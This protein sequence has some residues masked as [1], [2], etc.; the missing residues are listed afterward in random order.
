MTGRKLLLSTAAAAMAWT[1]IV[2]AT[3]GLDVRI[4]G[5]PLRARDTFRAA[6]LSGALLLVYA[7]AYR[8]AFGADVE[9]LADIWRRRSPVIAAGAALVA[10]AVSL[11]F[12]SFAVAGADTYGYVSQAYDWAR[13]QLPAAI[14]LPVQFPWPSADLLTTP[15]GYRPGPQPHTM[16]PTY[17]PGLPLLMAVMLSVGPIGPFLITPACAAITVWLT[18]LLG[19]RVAGPAVGA[20]AAILIAASPVEQFQSLWAMSDVPSAACWTAAVLASLGTSR[21]S[22]AIGGLGTALALFVRPNLPLLALVPLAVVLTENITRRE[23]F[24]RAALFCAP[25]LPVVV[26]VGALNALWYG[27]PLRSGYGAAGELYAFENVRTNLQRY[28]AWLWQS[29]SAFVLFAALPLLPFAR[30][31]AARRSVIA[32]YA[33]VAATCACYVAYAPFDDWWY[34]RFLL[35]AWGAFAVLMAMG[36]VSVA[37]AGWRPWGAVAAALL[38]LASVMTNVSFSTEK[39]LY[40]VMRAG[41]RRY[42]DVGRFAG[43]T[44]PA[45]AVVLTMQHSGAIRFYGGKLTIRYDFLDKDRARQVP[46]D[47]ERLGYHPFMAIDDWEAQYVRLQ[48]GFA[49][50]APLPWP[51]LARMRENG[52]VTIFDLSKA[53]VT[54]PA[55]IEPGGQPLCPAPVPLTLR[56]GSS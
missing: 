48:F 31:S 15:L 56:A 18:Y 21:R 41:E 3:G 8:A 9:L 10:L 55:S 13:G 44:L 29:Q 22:A 1:V 24:I 49:P 42:I 35:P 14:P 36:I 11:R 26:V 33:T 20:T 47:L 40:S 45:N 7:F 2:Y 38:V 51:V 52:G 17:A 50:D 30:R 37:R 53:G 27:G 19:R 25:L 32:L 4:A 34:L 43:G 16:V 46:A 23:R 5:V 54:Q 6:A 12:S 28:P 39:G